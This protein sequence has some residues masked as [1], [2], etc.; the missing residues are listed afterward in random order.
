MKKVIAFILI[1]MMIFPAAYAEEI[2]LEPIGHRI[3]REA[4]LWLGTPY[5]TSDGSDGYGSEVDCSGLVLQV[6]K[7]F[8]VELPR[9]SYEQAAEGEMIPLNE[10]VPGDIVCFVYE[11]GNIGH[12]GIYIG[13]ES[14][15]HSPRPEKNVEI[16]VNFEDWGSI[17]AV[18]GRR[19][20]IDS[21]YIP[22]PLPEETDMEITEALSKPNTLTTEHLTGID[23]THPIDITEPRT[24]ILQINNPV[25]TVNGEEKPVDE[26]GEISPCI[27]NNRTHLPLRS[28]AEEFGAEVRWLGGEPSEINLKYGDNEINLWIDADY[29][30]V[31]GQTVY[32]DST[33]VIINDKT[34]LPI[35][36]IADE[37]GWNLKWNENEK[38]VTLSVN[39][40]DSVDNS[41]GF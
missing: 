13:G 6:Y 18:Y 15:I 2:A 36:F 26:S 30:T 34:F 41:Y 9:V 25:M 12:V 38:T 35:R 17:K 29:A 8:G 28:V 16:S 33:P 11:D 14:M 37:F 24:I 4:A 20:E 32:I 1:F 10:M 40:E 21:D 31:N 5:G 22:S 27:I 3:V 7:A 19:I 39:Q 23:I